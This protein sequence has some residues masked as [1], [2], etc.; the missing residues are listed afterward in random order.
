MYNIS[1]EIIDVIIDRLSGRDIKGKPGCALS[2][3]ATISPRWQLA[4]ERRLFSSIAITSSELD[5][6]KEMFATHR[7]RMLLHKLCYDALLPAHEERTIWEVESR[8]DHVSNVG[9]LSAAVHAIMSE[10]HDWKETGTV[11]EFALDIYSPLDVGRRP[12]TMGYGIGNERTGGRFLKLDLEDGTIPTV[13]QIASFR[14]PR[15]I[16]RSVIPSVI[17]QLLAAM[18][19]VE[20]VDLELLE[21]SVRKPCLRMGHRALFCRGLDALE[22]AGLR[23]LK[24]HFEGGP[25]PTNH[26]FRLREAGKDMNDQ[27][28]QALRQLARSSPLL[29]RLT[30]SGFMVS[31]ALFNGDTIWP[32]LQRLDITVGIMAPSGEWYYTGSLDHVELDD[33]QREL[34]SRLDAISGDDLEEPSTTQEEQDLTES[35]NQTWTADQED[36]E[37]READVRLA[38]AAGPRDVRP[39]RAR[40][41]GRGDAEDAAPP[42]ALLPDGHHAERVRRYVV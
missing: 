8:E 7:R 20:C 22:L 1:N 23:D 32:N 40:H 9:A 6:F 25:D 14:F 18:P 19:S 21:P 39:A 26:S 36:A 10:L 12:R 4:V 28:G 17:T 37:R 3:Y 33:D 5:R 16:G 15:I 24:L 34:L 41:D 13:P 11:F 30:L 42:A 31:P 27:L 35:H 38:H 29:E 2:S